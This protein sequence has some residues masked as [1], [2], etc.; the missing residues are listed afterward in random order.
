MNNDILINNC[1]RLIKAYK[2]GELGDMR[3]PEDSKPQVFNSFEEQL[4]YFTL[5]MSLNYQRNSYTLWESVLQ[6][7]EQ[8]LNIFSVDFCSSLDEEVLRKLLLQ[9][10]IAL[11]PNKHI[12]T[13]KT[14]CRTIF[15]NWGSIE[16]LLEFVEY[17]FLKLQQTIQIDFKKGFPYLSG[18]K[19]FHYWC[20]ILII[21]CGVRLN[22]SNYIEIAPD[23]HVLQASIL[24]GVITK[25]QA[26]NVSKDKISSIWR[27]KLSSSN[28]NPI[29]MHSPLWFWSRNNFQFR[30]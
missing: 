28:I 19:I 16:K 24:L 29:D 9:N 15:E 22:N 21:Y 2:Q 1:K 20:Y 14:I 30:L 11:Q 8:N 12:L 13:W 5:P 18:P 6:T 7:Y 27:Q 23:T 4:F 10:K 25:E 3:M 26:L 17:D